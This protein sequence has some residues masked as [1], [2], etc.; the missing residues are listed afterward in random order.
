MFHK[1]RDVRDKIARLL[2]E[3]GY[4]VQK[5]VRISRGYRVDLL[6]E[7][8]GISRAIEVKISPRGIMDDISKGYHLLRL[9]EITE[10]YVAT[11]SELIDED[12]LASAQ[13]IGVGLISLTGSE[14]D[15]RVMSW[16]LK[17]PELVGSG[18]IAPGSISPGSQVQVQRS[19]RNGGQKL[20]KDLVAYCIPSG[21]FTYAPNARRQ[22]KRRFLDPDQEW[23]VQFLINVKKVATPGKYPLSTVVKA[24][25]A[26]R[27]DITFE[28]EIAEL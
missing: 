14:L 24:E 3:E 25:N 2:T 18:R 15:W 28:I 12:H 10:V 13:Q 20:A 1:E 11:L 6:A 23:S 16:H 7:K 4:K 26:Q 8:D 27:S 17:P 5:E 22:F 9:P 21:P 19:V